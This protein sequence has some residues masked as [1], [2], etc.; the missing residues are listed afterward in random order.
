MLQQEGGGGLA[1]PQVQLWAS[2]DSGAKG[3]VARAAVTEK[4]W[5]VVQIS[6]ACGGC[7]GRGHGTRWRCHMSSPVGVRSFNIFSWLLLRC[8]TI[9][10]LPIVAEDPC[11]NDTDTLVQCLLVPLIVDL[12][13]Q[14]LSI[15]I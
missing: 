5:K 13:E 3:Q 1:A 2:A 15:K 7:K 8:G 9:L 11:P 14:F 12:F 10:S 4:N 6:E